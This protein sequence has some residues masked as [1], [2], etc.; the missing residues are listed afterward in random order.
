MGAGAT[1]TVESVLPPG[2]LLLAVD[3]G[4]VDN[5]VT[6]VVLP[7]EE[8]TPIVED[9]SLLDRV[10]VLIAEE[11]RAAAVVGGSI[12]TAEDAVERAVGVVRAGGADHPVSCLADMPDKACGLNIVQMVALC[13]FGAFWFCFCTLYSARAAC[14][15]STLTIVQRKFYNL[16]HPLEPRKR[17]TESKCSTITAEV[18]W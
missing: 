12:Y 1:T 8:H 13:V 16:Y 18:L 4:L 5:S 3:V 14:A 2:E 11:G 17:Q 6:T 7:Q 9:T 10:D 15:P